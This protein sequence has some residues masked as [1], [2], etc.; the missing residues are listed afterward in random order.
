LA[1]VDEASTSDVHLVIFDC[2]GVLVDSERVSNQVLANL[3][4]ESG[5]QLTLEETVENF[6]GKTLALTLQRVQELLGRPPPEDFLEELKRRTKQGLEADLCSMAGAE[7]VISSLSVPCC[8]A[9]NGDRAKMLFTLSKTGL[10]PYFKEHMFCAED[11]AAPKPAPDLFLHAAETCGVS[12][13]HCIVVED[14][15]GGVSAAR[16]AGMR[17]YAFAGLTPRSRLLAARPTGMIHALPEL[18][19]ILA[20]ARGA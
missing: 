10:L 13:A 11:V 8:V 6:M 18:L 3:L 14:T 12:P 19:Q 17:V 16:A 20:D 4:S 5:V 15:P 7:E 2:D 1:A 9:S